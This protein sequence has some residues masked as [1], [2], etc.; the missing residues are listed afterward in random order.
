MDLREGTLWALI[1]VARGDHLRVGYSL[2]WD[3]S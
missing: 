1:C 3:M 2:C